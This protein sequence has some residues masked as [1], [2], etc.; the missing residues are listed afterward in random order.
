M[1]ALKKKFNLNWLEN[2]S[3]ISGQLY[4]FLGG[5]HWNNL[6][7]GDVGVTQWNEGHLLRGIDEVN[8]KGSNA[9]SK[10]E[11]HLEK[12]RKW[13]SNIIK[14]FTIHNIKKTINS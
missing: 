6:K 9:E 3:H 14:L 7:H 12:D 2:S 13:K 8:Y 5:L 11:H 4:A 1:P 10:N